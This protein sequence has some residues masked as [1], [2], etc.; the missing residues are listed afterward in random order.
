MKK[1]TKPPGR[2]RRANNYDPY[3]RLAAA[4]VNK[5]AHDY[6]KLARQLTSPYLDED[7][8][9]SM[10]VEANN[11]EAWLLDPLNEMVNCVG[12]DVELIEE[13]I[14]HASEGHDIT[15]FELHKQVN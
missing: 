6:Y 15:T 2:W 13:F 14:N 3:K 9:A 11:I 4:V 12:L 8:A 5:A 7:K 10:E 1:A